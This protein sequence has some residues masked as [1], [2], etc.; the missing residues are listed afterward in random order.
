MCVSR[1]YR[2]LIDGGV[3]DEE[4][5]RLCVAAE[6]GGDGL[7]RRQRASRAR[8]RRAEA[9]AGAT[10]VPDCP[11]CLE[12]VSAPCRRMRCCGVYMHAHCLV[13]AARHNFSRCGHCNQCL[14]CTFQ[15]EGVRCDACG[16][17]VAV[18]QREGLERGRV[19]A[20]RW[21]GQEPDRRSSRSSSPALRIGARPGTR[22]PWTAPSSG[23]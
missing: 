2:A 3:R 22:R 14:A 17:R 15:P 7:S 6:V 4:A 13:L 1:Q 5:R 19:A 20:E 11:L 18:A 23:T 12:P 10:G 16:E 8:E 9:R 21:I